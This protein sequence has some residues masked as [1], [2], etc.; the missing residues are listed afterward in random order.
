MLSTIA[1]LAT[2]ALGPEQALP[3]SRAELEPRRFRLRTGSLEL[4]V[5]WRPTLSSDGEYPPPCGFNALCGVTPRLGFDFEFGSRAVR[6]LIGSYRAPVPIFPGD[7][8][9]IEAYMIEA[10]VLFGNEKIRAGVVGNGGA[11]VNAGGALI[12]RASPW[13][14]RR[15]HRHGL[16]LRVSTSI[17]APLGVALSYRWYPRKLDRRYPPG[18]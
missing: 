6:L 15:G 5:G 7:I 11:A 14:D 12:V 1:L 18:R 4:G 16:D 2:L 8:M 13:V 3:P 9:V 17:F 10:G